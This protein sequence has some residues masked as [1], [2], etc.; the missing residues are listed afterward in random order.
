LSEESKLVVET[1]LDGD[2]IGEPLDVSVATKPEGV[3]FIPSTGEMLIA[4]E[5]NELLFFTARTDTDA[6]TV[7]PPGDGEP[8]ES[9]AVPSTPDPDASSAIVLSYWVALPLAVLAASCFM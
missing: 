3:Y 9:P 7:L 5:P 8:T 4:S 2:I 1:T 6:P